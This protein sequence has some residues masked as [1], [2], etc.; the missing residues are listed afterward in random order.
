MSKNLKLKVEI[1]KDGANTVT[2]APQALMCAPPPADRWKATFKVRGAEISFRSYR[3]DRDRAL[4]E[5]VVLLHQ[6][7]EE[8]FGVQLLDIVRL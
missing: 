4:V 1:T 3:E 7:I 5:M 8:P 6:Y 2:L